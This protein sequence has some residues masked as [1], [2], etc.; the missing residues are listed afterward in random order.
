MS[1]II[2]S[3]VFAVAAGFN[4]GGNMLAVAASSRT[5]PP[6]FAYLV[7]IALACAGPLVVGTAVARTTGNGVADFHSIGTAPLLAGIA[8]GVMTVLTAYGLRVPTSMSV[9]LFSSMIGALWAGPGLAAVRWADVAKIGISMG[10]SILV[11]F[12]AGIVAYAIVAWLLTRVR[13]KIA[14]RI[15]ALQYVT[16]G[17]LA[18]GYGANDLEKSAGL[19]AAGIPSATFSVPVWTLAVAVV[20]FAFGMAVGGVRV[21]KTVGGK[22]FS[23]RP[24]HALAFQL[25]ASS[26]VITASVFGGP[27][28]TTETTAS[29]IM[30]V[31]AAVNPRA[32]HWQVAAHIVLAWLVTAPF[33]LGAGGL[34]EFLLRRF[35]H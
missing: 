32:V 7:I 34:S 12:V 15:V 6:A 24:Q 9:A 26:T 1:V 21:A 10:G 35:L 29:A 2:A 14:E 33:A 23:I 4:D 27:L 18:F 16:V 3:A 19:L 20:C 5:I 22:L 17:L 13:R 8:G 31:G 25:A 30:G 28:S 11:G